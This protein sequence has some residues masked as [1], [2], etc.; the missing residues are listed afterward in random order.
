M[1]PGLSCSTAGEI[2][3]TQGLNPCLLQWQTDSFPLSH[4][5]EVQKASFTLSTGRKRFPTRLCSTGAS[6]VALVV[7][8]HLPVQEM[9]ESW[10]QSLG[11]EDPLE[12]VMAT[13]SSILAWRIP[14]AE[15][16]GGL[17]SR[18]PHQ[19]AAPWVWLARGSGC[20]CSTEGH[21]MKYQQGVDGEVL[22]R[23]H[24]IEA[25]S[26]VLLS[27]IQLK[28]LCQLPW[29]GPTRRSPTAISAFLSVYE[30]LEK[31]DSD[32]HGFS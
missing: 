29:A 24:P 18:L 10:V 8:N 4:Q 13:H 14:W 15:E 9:Q 26:G 27:Y 25:V 12:G 19:Q 5:W 22:W 20:L 23:R 17:Q 2:F 16:P 3:L 28:P 21:G 7:K 1:L 31:S 11:Q 32:C 30:V 6:Q